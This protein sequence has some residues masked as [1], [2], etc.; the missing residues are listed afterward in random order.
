VIGEVVTGE[1]ITDDQIR[2]WES[3]AEGACDDQP[4]R[5][6]VIGLA[7]TALAPPFDGSRASRSVAREQ[8]AARINMRRAAAARTARTA[9]WDERRRTQP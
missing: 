6:E 4:A 2:E 3:E 7:T 1:T 9:E 8:I 5:W